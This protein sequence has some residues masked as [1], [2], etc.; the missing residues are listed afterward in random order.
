MTEPTEPNHT[1]PE[2]VAQRTHDHAHCHAH[3]SGHSHG[4]GTTNTNM[5]WAFLLNLSFAVIELIGGFFTNSLA[6]MADALHDFGDATAIAVAWWLERRANAKPSVTFSYGLRRLSLL[7]ALI[8]TFIIF[9]SGIFILAVALPRLLQPETVETT[10]MFWLAL[11]GVAV[12]A[13]AAWRLRRE[14]TFNAKVM[15]WHLYEDLL[16]WLAVLV[17]STVMWVRPTPILDPL[18]AIAITVFVLWNIVRHLR[19]TMALFLQGVPDSISLATIEQEL[20]QLAPVRSCHHT[21]IWSLDGEHHVLTTHLLVQEQSSNAQ[22][23]S[24]KRAVQ[25]LA[26][27]HGFSHTTI[28]IEYENADCS[29][30]GS[31]IHPER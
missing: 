20:M 17:V 23:Q 16:G 24:L 21:H 22:V 31:A 2:P 18:L 9:S 27:E 11:L 12:N 29:M 28:E 15:A 1:R 25:A 13:Y 8:N 3:H 14:Q 10:G 5:R 4:Q 7:G 6:I 26:R 19:R 30:S